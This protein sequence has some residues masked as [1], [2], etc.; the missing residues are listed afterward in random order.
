LS[1]Y[2]HIVITRP[3]QE[4]RELAEMLAPSGIESI[5]LP[6]WDFHANNLFSDQLNNLRRAAGSS[7]PPLLIFTSPRSVAYGLGQI[8]PEVL[9]RARIA[10]IGATT[11]D[12]LRAAGAVVSL[13]PARGYTSEDLLE[14]LGSQSGKNKGTA[15]AVF[16]LAAPG[17]RTALGE[18][19]KAQ[20]HEPQMLMVYG[21]RATTITSGAI[22]AIEQAA[23]L[24]TVWTSANTMD[25]LSR[26]LPARCWSRLCRYDWLVIS[27]RL[28]RAARAFSPRHIYLAG[29]PSNADI[30]AAIQGLPEQ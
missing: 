30:F 2:S 10:A 13:Q 8:P 29:G 19:L 4:A 12:L 6:A 14:T 27:D 5:I 7:N 24:L 21:R 26:R 18:G 20:G 15:G 11:A 25:A 1:T 28:Q 17:G 3:E 23:N 16:I 9:Q 22:E